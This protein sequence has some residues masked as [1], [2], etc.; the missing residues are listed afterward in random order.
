[1][2]RGIRRARAIVLLG[3]ILVCFGCT[4]KSAQLQKGIAPPDKT[5]LDTGDTYLKRG[6]YLTA[7]L[8]YQTL[9]NTYPDSDLTADA[10]FAIGDTFYEA[11]GTENTLLA[12]NQYKSF[13]TFFGSDH[14]K[15]A[16]AQMKIIAGNFRMMNTP[17][18]DTQYAEN[19][20]REIENM[21][22]RHPGSDYIPIVRAMKV[23][24]EDNLARGDLGVAE[25]YL[26]GGNLVGPMQRYTHIYDN[27]KNFEEMD[28]VVYR[29][30]ELFDRVS[31]QS[32][33]SVSAAAAAADA[34][35]WYSRLAEGY[36]FSK[37]YETVTKR[38][39]EMGYIIPEVNEALAATNQ[40]NVRPSGGFSPLNLLADFGRALGFI[41]LPDAYENARKAIEEE[42][43]AAI[44]AAA[45]AAAAA[46]TGDSTDIEFTIRKTAPGDPTDETPD[47]ETGSVPGSSGG[48]SPSGGAGQQ[49][50]PGGARYQKPQQ[51]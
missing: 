26:R 28:Y 17:D 40:A 10:Y 35:I 24:A 3:V 2:G 45:A 47:P 49:G 51:R 13:I 32:P 9:L 1:M 37:Y 11:G 43:Q 18:R 46:G 21:E 12:E 22:R 23:K 19:T 16:D 4:Q 14:H 5:L 44:K 29:I 36:P 31:E 8:T 6:Q 20:L 7:R 25:F 41:S 38:L 48:T 42:K 39:E 33:N 50:K 30:G 27:F 34:A 15:A